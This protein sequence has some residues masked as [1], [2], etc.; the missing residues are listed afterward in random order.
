ML[1]SRT[2]SINEAGLALAER[3]KVG[4]VITCGKAGT[5]IFQRDASGSVRLVSMSSYG[6]LFSSQFAIVCL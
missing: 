3:V 1:I 4:V 5:K 6:W 2:K